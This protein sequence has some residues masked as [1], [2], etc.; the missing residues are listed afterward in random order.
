MKRFQVLDSFRGLCALSVAI[1]HVHISQ[2]FGEWAFFRNA[3]YLVSFFFVLSGFV[4]CHTYGRRLQANGQFRQF[5]ITR[6]MRLYPL[7]VFVLGL[8]IGL[9]CVKLA[10]EHS[11][12]SFS[13]G[14]FTGQRAP[15]EIIPN[16]L[17]L[18][19][20]WPGFNPQSFNF[21][22][23]SISVEY[24][25]Y[26][27]FAGILLLSPASALKVFA[28]LSFI[29]TVM[30]LLGIAPLA[31]PV[32]QGLSCFFAGVMTYQ[33]YL[34]IQAWRGSAWLYTVVEATGIT[35]V[36]I[37]MVS[38]LPQKQIML[39]LLFCAVILMFSF[40]G[41][42]LSKALKARPFEQLGTLSYSIYMTHAMILFTATLSLL[43]VGKF[44]GQS[45][46]TYPTEGPG[47]YLS[48]NN[49]ILDNLLL[50]TLLV[51]II[52]LSALTYHFV[53]LRGIQWGKRWA[54]K[55]NLMPGAKPANTP[56]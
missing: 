20:W 49:P 42:L 46:V 25:I 26:M 34:M 22:A 15:Q 8:A 17:L 6:T 35:L 45:W 2:S 54:R 14:S 18:Q 11:G 27:I 30:L 56:V 44:S 10:A 9:E 5:F 23:W 43:M 32:L 39:T 55:G 36:A 21:P 33:I 24:Y 1:Y 38:D 16:L 4:M 51:V 31:E 53:E 37:A 52:A 13:Q 3:H 47:P 41:G 48:F 19:S 50:V 40:E 7:H 29:A 12:L 28:V